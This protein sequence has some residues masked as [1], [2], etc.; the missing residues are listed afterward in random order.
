MATGDP[1]SIVVLISGRGSNL[2]A[3]IDAVAAGR[4]TGRITGVISNVPGALGLER[5]RMF[6]IPTAVVDHT[7]F[8]SRTAFEQALLD[9]MERYTPDL[10]VLAGFMRI[11]GAEVVRRFT[12]RM[13]NIHPSLLP[14]LRGLRTH[15]RALQAQLTRHGCSVHFVTTDLDSGPVILQAEVPVY[16]EDDADTLAARVLRQEHIIYPLAIRWFAQGRL[17]LQDDRVVLDGRV[18]TAPLKLDTLPSNL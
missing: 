14:D 11:L 13:L 3:L 8:L 16:P 12:G 10:V 17:A 15:T 6:G 7:R 5:A 1:L 18:L 9:A 4:I 2:Q